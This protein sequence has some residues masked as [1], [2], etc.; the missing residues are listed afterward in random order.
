[1]IYK[2]LD[3]GIGSQKFI[4]VVNRALLKETVYGKHEF[5]L[6]SFGG[7]MKHFDEVEDIFS[8][9]FPVN[10]HI[11]GDDMGVIGV[12]HY[13]ASAKNNNHFLFEISNRG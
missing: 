13:F 1:M 8:A 3:I 2:A 10:Y 11:D 12:I 9:E 7:A 6:N 4:D 5:V